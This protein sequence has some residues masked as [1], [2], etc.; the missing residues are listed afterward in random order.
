MVVWVAQGLSGV[1]TIAWAQWINDAE[2][3]GQVKRDPTR[4]HITLVLLL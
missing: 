1:G 3:G 4:G 2:G